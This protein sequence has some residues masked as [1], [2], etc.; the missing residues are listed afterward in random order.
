L[1]ERSLVREEQGAFVLVQQEIEIDIPDSVQAVIEERLD[2]IGKDLHR[3]LSYASVQGERFVGTVLAQLLRSDEI[4]VLERLNL[5]ERVHKLIR[6]LEASHLIIKVGGEY[7]FIHALIQQTL[8]N[9]LSVGQRRHLHGAI[10]QLLESLYGENASLYAADLAIHFERGGDM[11]KAIPYY[12]Q[13]GR[14][15]LAIFALDDALL[16]AEKVRELAAQIPD[17]EQATAWQLDALIQIA[18]THH[19]KAEYDASLAACEE[20]EALCQNNE[21]AEQHAYVLYWRSTILNSLG[22]YLEALRPNQQ[23]LDLLGDSPTDRRLQGYLYTSSHSDFLEQNF[24]TN[25]RYQRLTIAMNIAQK[26]NLSDV[27]L[28]VISRRAWLAMQQE[29]KQPK[30]AL[31]HA[32]EALQLA[33]N[34]NNI[35]QQIS[36]YRAMAWAF[37]YLKQDRKELECL[38][39]AMMVARQ[40]GLPRELHM[41]LFSM[42]NYWHTTAEDWQKSLHLARESMGVSETYNFPPYA[43]LLRRWFST[44]LGLGLWDEAEQVLE[45]YRALYQRRNQKHLDTIRHCRMHGQ[46]SYVRGCSQQAYTFLKTAIEHFEEHGAEGDDEGPV[47][48]AQVNLGLVMI[49]QNMLSQSLDYLDQSAQYWK[50]QKRPVALA[51]CL[52]GTAQIDMLSGNYQQAI[53]RLR[54]GL[55]E[56][57]GVPADP[58]IGWPVWQHVCVDLGRALLATGETEEALQHAMFG[59]QK[60]KKW[61]HFLLG[62]AAFVVGQILVAQGKR[63]E[64][65]T[66]LHEARRDWQRLELTHHLPA[67]EAF[68]QEHGLETA[69]S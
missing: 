67:W 26:Y 4:D 53:T 3:L 42:S 21:F 30:E 61:G 6:E 56:S 60:F 13:A 15:A 27:K 8:Y 2:L 20:G 51:Q 35:V 34:Q 39:Y 18:E 46:L 25:Q 50:E 31:R 44:A 57:E 47:R 1:H 68:M 43:V 52:R 65:L 24:P 22:R 38:Q 54:K 29:V 63:E 33:K 16:Y 62:E 11:T 41:T 19:R 69:S 48:E 66:Y 59:Y 10:A 36:S 49:Q 32:Q 58:L 17:K 5:L 14:A 23:A 9:N 55:S 64:A 40:Y 7:Q 28:R 37:R 12:L 45:H